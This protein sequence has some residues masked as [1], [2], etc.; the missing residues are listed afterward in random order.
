MAWWRSGATAAAALLGIAGS[1]FLVA[2]RTTDAAFTASTTSSGSWASGTVTLSNDSA[3]ATFGA[4]DLLPGSTGTRCID[5]DYTG[6]LSAWVRLYVSSSSGTLGSDIDWTVERGSGGGLGSC[7]GFTPWTTLYTGSLADFAA[8]RTDWRSG[9][10]GF[11]PTTP[12]HAVYRF[13]YTLRDDAPNSAQGTSATASLTWEARDTPAVSRG[14]TALSCVSFSGWAGCP[15]ATALKYAWGVTVSPDGRDVYV[16]TGENSSAVLTFR[17]DLSTGALTQSGCFSSYATAGCTTVASLDYAH[18]VAVSPD[19]RNVYVTSEYGD[20]VTVF[21]RDRSS[22]ALT[23]L[24]GTSG[25]VSRDGTGGAC[26]TF[27][28]LDFPRELVVSPDGRDVYVATSLSR[29][30]ELER[31]PTTGALTPLAGL[32]GCYGWSSGGATCRSGGWFTDFQSI[33]ISP[34]GRTVYAG[35]QDGVL[36]L[37]RDAASGALAR[38]PGTAGCISTWDGSCASDAL[39]EWAEGVAV[40]PDGGQLIVSSQTR[41]AVVVY[42]RDRVTGGLSARTQCVNRTGAGGCVT[43]PQLAGPRAV[44]VS[45]DGTDVYV[46]LEA[47]W[48]LSALARDPVTG[49]LSARPGPSGCAVSDG[50]DGCQ[51]APG[52]EQPRGVAVA[53]DGRHLYVTG[54]KNQGWVQAFSR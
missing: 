49:A 52:V 1:G 47:E 11:E 21:A 36:A 51:A 28:A 30:V 41:D 5:V 6:S 31:D 24:A 39:L 27:P 48:G 29:V 25:C 23:P 38:V 9:L 16:A 32:D 2:D 22:G 20:A 53:P 46:T 19:G 12:G 4:S 35:G 8:T 40:T 3:T 43:V 26:A 50:S 37:A 18:D 14:V 42:G 10:A 54:F 13:T 7:S 33:A 15:V 45:P 34:D 44:K 17:R